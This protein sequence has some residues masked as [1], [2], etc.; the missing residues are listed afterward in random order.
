MT[1]VLS[2]NTNSR[3]HILENSRNNSSTEVQSMINQSRRSSYL[4]VD[5]FRCDDYSKPKFELDDSHFY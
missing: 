2:H 5:Q 3:L 1:S 4:T